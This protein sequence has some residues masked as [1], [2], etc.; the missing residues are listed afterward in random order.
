VQALIGFYSGPDFKAIVNDTVEAI[1]EVIQTKKELTSVV[2]SLEK[3]I[4]SQDEIEK[5]LDN[6]KDMITNKI[7]E[8]L[9]H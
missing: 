1:K 6:G 7:R 3:T 9:D 4:G 5:K 8:I 2:K